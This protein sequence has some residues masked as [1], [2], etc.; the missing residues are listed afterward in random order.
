MLSQSGSFATETALFKITE[1][2][3][4]DAENPFVKML[5]QVCLN[6]F[7]FSMRPE[8][9]QNNDIVLKIKLVASLTSYVL[10]KQIN[11]LSGDCIC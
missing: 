8:H 7:I 1:Y 4:D 9:A 10:E 11:I 6:L 5:H 3:N 2:V